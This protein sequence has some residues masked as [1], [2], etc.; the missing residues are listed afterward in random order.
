MLSGTCR[1]RNAERIHA[2]GV[3][4]AGERVCAGHRILV[5]RV[6]DEGGNFGL[7]GRICPAERNLDG[8][9]RARTCENVA[10]A[11][12][13]ERAKDIH[14][15]DAEHRFDVVAIAISENSKACFSP[16]RFGVVLVQKERDFG[17]RVAGT[18]GNAKK[19]ERFSD[20]VLDVLV[21]VPDAFIIASVACGGIC[22][23]C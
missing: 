7:L 23:C 22:P 16:N 1:R 12:G 9:N 2:Q 18:D 19:P 17:T 15:I 11:S 21:L 13:I 10:L 5:E 6:R 20:F 4:Y 3:G 14:G 8:V